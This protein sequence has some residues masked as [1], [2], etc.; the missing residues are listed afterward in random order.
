ML[1]SWTAA[2]LIPFS[3]QMGRLRQET[4]DLHQDSFC[5]THV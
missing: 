3:I 4:E 5:F 2:N 1:G